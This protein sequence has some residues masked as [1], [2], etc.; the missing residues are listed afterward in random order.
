MYQSRRCPNLQD[1][2]LIVSRYCIVESNHDIEPVTGSDNLNQKIIQWGCKY[3]STHGYTL[4]SSLPEN[5]QNTPW[6]YVIRIATSDGYIYLKHTPKLLALEA[7]IIQILHDQFHAS[8]PV[9]IA[10]NDEL[11]CFLMKDAGRSLREILK[12]QFDAELICKAI[13]QFTSL[14]LSV[15]DHVNI[16]F[17]IG[18][19]DWRLNK[20]PD[21]YTQLIT[22]KQ[23]LLIEDG[24]SK[25]ELEE[26]EV[27]IPSVNHLC[28]K[29]SAFSI[30]Q[31]MVQPD[32]NDNNTLIDDVSQNITIIDLG[33]IVISHPFFSI[34]TVCNK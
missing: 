13:E 28:N 19:P 11:N 31:T 30:K 7:I 2:F 18:V 17:N 23:D 27:L 3:L 15:A 6:S 16:F 20:L 9:V 26:L 25:K 33:E 22:Q 14:Q 34:L 29:L 10:H 24:L 8:V 32:F 5:V 4:K 1:R 21:L 12:K